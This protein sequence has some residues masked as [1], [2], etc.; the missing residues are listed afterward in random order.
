MLG[1]R[2][3]LP[4]SSVP[5]H[6]HIHFSSSPLASFSLYAV[7]NIVQSFLSLSLHTPMP[8]P[9]PL[10][11]FSVIANMRG[12]FP[13]SCHI[14]AYILLPLLLIHLLPQVSTSKLSNTRTSHSLFGTSAVRYVNMVTQNSRDLSMEAMPDTFQ[15][16][17]SFIVNRTRS[18]LCGDTV[19]FPNP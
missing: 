14:F 13:L 15:I 1:A 18:V 2:S 11:T 5:F 19:R 8:L 3:N 9:L 4:P 7:V 6:L 16:P 17:V 12:T 10:F